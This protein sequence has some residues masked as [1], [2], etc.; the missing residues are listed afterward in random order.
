MSR[1]IKYL[2]FL[3]FILGGLAGFITSYYQHKDDFSRLGF[4]TEYKFH[5]PVTFVQQLKGDPDAGRK[6]F[7]EFCSACHGKIPTIDLPAPR[8]G[9]KRIWQAYKKIGLPELLKMTINGKGA[10]PARGGCFECSDDQ[11]R[12]AINYILTQSL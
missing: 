7:I 6:I 11:L 8:I 4:E 12:E 10:M 2:Y 5:S 9:D 1:F 3:I